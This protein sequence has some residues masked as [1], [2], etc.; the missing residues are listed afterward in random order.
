MLV[1]LTCPSHTKVGK[2]LIISNTSEWESVV[3][4]PNTG[5]SFAYAVSEAESTRFMSSLDH[6]KVPGSNV[7]HATDPTKYKAQMWVVKEIGG[8]NVESFERKGNY[9]RETFERFKSLLFVSFDR[10][11]L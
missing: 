11:L 10:F 4:L 8:E 5:D 3:A 6:L 7:P 9:L 1:T 2:P